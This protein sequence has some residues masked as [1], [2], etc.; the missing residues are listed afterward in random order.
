MANRDLVTIDVGEEAV[1]RHVCGRL[2]EAGVLP[3]AQ[4]AGSS[5]VARR[6]DEQMT[7]RPCC[8]P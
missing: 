3:T 8:D 6:G 4:Q 1:T 2:Q 7:F 5:L